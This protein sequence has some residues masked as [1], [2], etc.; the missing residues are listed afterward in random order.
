MSFK[1]Q[2]P[3]SFKATSLEIAG[4]TYKVE[5]AVVESEIDIL[6]ILA[7]LGFKRTLTEIKAESK[8]E[9]AAAK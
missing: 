9:A 7:P 1:Y 8:K 2:A 4:C 5:E 6:H 3:E